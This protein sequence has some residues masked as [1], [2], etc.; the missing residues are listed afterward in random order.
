M[1]GELSYVHTFLRLRVRAKR[2]WF[3][4][5]LRIPRDASIMSVEGA[6]V[7]LIHTHQ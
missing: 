3:F 1:N 7:I 6:I 2:E 5:S 4:E